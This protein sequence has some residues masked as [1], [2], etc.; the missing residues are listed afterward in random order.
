MNF[1]SGGMRNNETKKLWHL[2]RKAKTY[3]FQVSMPASGKSAYQQMI[4]ETL[5]FKT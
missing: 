1:K 4:I 3:F 5:A 2:L